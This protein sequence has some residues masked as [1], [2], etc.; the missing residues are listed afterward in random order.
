MRLNK[1]AILI[2]VFWVSF[3]YANPLQQVRDFTSEQ[4]SDNLFVLKSTGSN[5]NVGIFMGETF[6]LLID[7]FVGNANNTKLVSAIR[8]LSDK[9]IKYIINTHSHSDHIGANSFYIELGADVISN[10]N[11][12]FYFNNELISSEDKY[13]IDVGNE[14]LD[15]LHFISHTT[16]DVIVHF[17]KNNII[18]MGDTY[19]HDTYPHA[20]AGG[21]KGQFE[22]I[23]KTLSLSNDSTKLI[24]AHGRFL[25]KKA[26]FLSFKE[27][28]ELWYEKIN[29]LNEQGE[30]MEVIVRN[31]ELINISKM[32][33]PFSLGYFE[34][35]VRKTVVAE[36]LISK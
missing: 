24:T 11:G 4:L 20:Y 18:F 27:K 32:F 36:R 6:I 2:A 33:R 17:R 23:N 14:K 12:Q 34:Q 26:E 16:D 25:T 5:T 13:T 22:V 8:K 28:S 30:S 9:P 15:L 1:Y 21:S 29:A 3:T 19:M 31:E 35:Q 7:P 10:R